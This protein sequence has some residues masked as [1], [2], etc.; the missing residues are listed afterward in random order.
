MNLAKCIIGL[1]LTPQKLE[2]GEQVEETK[3][4]EQQGLQENN[5]T[6]PM[7]SVDRRIKM[8]EESVVPCLKLIP[9]IL[10]SDVQWE[11]SMHY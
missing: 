7:S 1:V 9:C 4:L 6:R 2:N 8:L 5:G 11:N 10:A 3:W